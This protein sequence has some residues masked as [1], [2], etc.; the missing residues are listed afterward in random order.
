MASAP[1]AFRVRVWQI[2]SRGRGPRTGRPPPEGANVGYSL[3]HLRMAPMKGRVEAG[4]VRQSR[5]LLRLDPAMLA[6]LVPLAPLHQPHNL[7]AIRAV[8]RC[9][10]CRRGPRDASRR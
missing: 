7:A 9:T 6:V 10:P 3:G 2:E 8:S 1:A 5:E 4:H